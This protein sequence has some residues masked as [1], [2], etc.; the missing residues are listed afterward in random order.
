MGEPYISGRIWISFQKIPLS[1][2]TY[3]VCLRF[4]SS[5]ICLILSSAG[6]K[7][8]FVQCLYL[9]ALPGLGGELKPIPS[10]SMK[11]VTSSLLLLVSFAFTTRDLTGLNVFPGSRALTTGPRSR[12]RPIRIIESPLS[13]RRRPEPAAPPVPL[14]LAAV[15]RTTTTIRTARQSATQVTGSATSS[16]VGSTARRGRAPLASSRPRTRLRVRSAEET[17]RRRAGSRAGSP[18]LEQDLYVGPERPPADSHSEEHQCGIC[19]NIQSH[20]VV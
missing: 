2:R 4:S 6:N 12:P 5:V 15:S 8:L 1:S 13:Q 18:P 7:Y 20:P 19:F 10:K 3:L 9:Q 16:A 17:A 11:M 14:A